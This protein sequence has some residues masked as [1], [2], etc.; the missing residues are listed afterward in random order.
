MYPEPLEY[1]FYLSNNSSKPVSHCYTFSFFPR[2]ITLIFTFRSTTDI[3]AK[4][5]GEAGTATLTVAVS[6]AVL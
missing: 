6:A 1:T 5:A 2:K 4:T 3:G